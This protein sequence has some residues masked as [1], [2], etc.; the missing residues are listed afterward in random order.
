MRLKPQDS[1][2]KL[3][4][5]S[6]EAQRTERSALAGEINRL[7]ASRNATARQVESEGLSLMEGL[8]KIEQEVAGR[9]S[10][11]LA[12][13]ASLEARRKALMAP[14]DDIKKGLKEREAQ[15]EK[16]EQHNLRKEKENLDTQALLAEKQAILSDWSVELTE[17]DA[18][19]SVR[20][21][22]LLEAEAFSAKSAQ[23]LADKWQDFREKEFETSQRL[24]KRAIDLANQAQQLEKD[25]AWL[26][27]E[28]IYLANERTLVD[29]RR[30]LLSQALKEKEI[31][32]DR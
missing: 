12:G 18:E 3:L 17:K 4:E 13:I 23:A 2:K 15:I 31:S 20:W 28:R 26:K 32:Y 9:K 6:L 27:Q 25:R 19:I 21:A 7:V 1:R 10:E 5:T 29:S 8:R 22:K 11:L 16:Q 24:E 14:L 30:L